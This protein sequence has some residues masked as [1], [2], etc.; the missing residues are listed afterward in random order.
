M[1]SVDCKGRDSVTGGF[2]HGL[3]SRCH[4]TIFVLMRTALLK[5]LALFGSFRGARDNSVT[6]FCE[7]DDMEWSRHFHLLI[8]FR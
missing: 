7:C 8:F 4:I 2:K 5:Y 1:S 6:I 3:F